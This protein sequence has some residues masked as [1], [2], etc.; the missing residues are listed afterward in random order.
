MW[1]G[2]IM[3]MQKNTSTSYVKKQA[4]TCVQIVLAE[5]QPNKGTEKAMHGAKRL[6]FN[7][8]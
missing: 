4:F 3:S 6:Y 7:V 1:A 5:I 2:N 8:L